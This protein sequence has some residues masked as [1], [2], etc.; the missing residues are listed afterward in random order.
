MAHF[1]WFGLLVFAVTTMLM[2][3]ASAQTLPKTEIECLALTIYFEARGEPDR[4]K[5]AVGYVVMNRVVDPSFPDSV[6]AVVKQGG[7]VPLYQCQFSWWCDGLSDEPTD[8]MSWQ[9]SY[10]IACLIYWQ[11]VDDPTQAALW[12]HADYAHPPWKDGLA[13][14]PTIGQHIF[15]H[16]ADEP[17]V[18]EVAEVPHHARSVLA[19]NAD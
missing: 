17:A 13:Q 1:Y 7:E 2:P 8:P 5:I 11:L 6:C 19:S 16:Q 14:G 3:P 10:W 9:Q 4:G 18:R 12:Y 15:Y